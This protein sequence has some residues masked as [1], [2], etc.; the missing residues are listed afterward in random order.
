MVIPYGFSGLDTNAVKKLTMGLDSPLDCRSDRSCRSEV[1]ATTRRYL[2]RTGTE[3]TAEDDP[4]TRA[5][6]GSKQ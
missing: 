2:L 4:G 1:E 6:M 5:G 3:D